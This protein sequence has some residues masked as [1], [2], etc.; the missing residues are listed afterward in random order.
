MSTFC[1]AGPNEDELFPDAAWS[2]WPK[3]PENSTN[4]Y[5]DRNQS[6]KY[7]TCT[8]AS[9]CCTQ[10][11]C[12]DESKVF[13]STL[14][15]H[16]STC[17]CPYPPFTLLLHMQLDN[18]HDMIIMQ[19]SKKS[20][21]ETPP[22]KLLFR[23]ASEPVSHSYGSHSVYPQQPGPALTRASSGTGRARDRPPNHHGHS[24]GQ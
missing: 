18:T 15:P 13:S 4:T 21:S 9:A 16:M 19:K 5:A 3:P 23:P 11:C 17:C 2:S 20:S 22:T 10:A 1:V 6:T 12:F 8:S 7:V 14:I 24:A